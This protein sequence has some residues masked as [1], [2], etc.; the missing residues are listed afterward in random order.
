MRRCL[1]GGGSGSAFSTTDSSTA[2]VRH[3]QFKDAANGQKSSV[4]TLFEQGTRCLSYALIT[5]VLSI[6]DSCQPQ[7]HYS[8]LVDSAKTAI[9]IYLSIFL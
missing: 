4:A 5:P 1:E 8:E 7:K 9:L 2:Q 6:P 3:S